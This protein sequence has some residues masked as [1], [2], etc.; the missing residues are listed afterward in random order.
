M[1]FAVVTLETEAGFTQKR[2]DSKTSKCFFSS[3][4]S[5]GN[6]ITNVPAYTT[7]RA[8]A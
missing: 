3:V 6:Q 1:G 7:L 2:T 8:E 4:W 5:A